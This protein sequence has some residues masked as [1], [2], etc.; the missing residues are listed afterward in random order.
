MKDINELRKE[1]DIIGKKFIY[2]SK[3]G[4]VTEGIIASLSDKNIAK[5]VGNF[6]MIMTVKGEIPIH[7]NYESKLE[8]AIIST[9]NVIYRLNEIEIL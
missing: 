8:E 5:G 2:K 1:Y 6:T 9:N 3:Y 4:G 7:D